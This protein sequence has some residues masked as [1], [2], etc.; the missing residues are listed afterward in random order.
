MTV[1]INEL[2]Q[3]SEDLGFKEIS[4]RLKKIETKLNKSDCPLV[5]PLVGEFSSGKTTLIN[6][7][8][9]SK[10]LE[11]ATRPT[12]ATIYEVHFGS[13]ECKAFVTDENGKTTELDDIKTL[14]NSELSDSAVVTV[15][16]TSKKVPSSIV[17][18]DTPGL[19]SPDPRHRQ[20]LIDF[21]PQ[22][23]AVLL[24][25]DINAQITR[26]LTDFVK[27]MSLSNK[28]L[29][30][31]LTKTDTKS[32]TE[33][34]ATRKY[35]EE[36]LNVNKEKIV[37]VSAQEGKLDELFNLFDSI[38]KDKTQ[39]L[40]KVNEER[41]RIIA[42]D[43]ATRVNE[44]LKAPNNSK[45]IEGQIAKKNIELRKIQRKIED[46]ISSAS[47]DI[48]DIQRKTS[49][50]FE[51]T[52]FDGLESL[53]SGKSSNYN[54]E[55]KAVIYNTA[56]LVLNEYKGQVKRILHDHAAKGI[57]NEEL[58]TSLLDQI[59]VSGLSIKGLSYNLDLDSLGHKYDKVIST[60][61][62]VALA[63]ALVAGTVATA[64][65]AASTIG[66]GAG[67][68]AGGAATGAAAT[69]GTA[70]GAAAETAAAVSTGVSALDTAS[71]IGSM[72]SAHKLKSEMKKAG[73]AFTN[74]VKKKS[75]V[76]ADKVK[77]AEGYTETFNK[78]YDHINLVESNVSSRIGSKGLLDSAIGAFT[79]KTMGKPQ[80]RRAIHQ[81]MD[82][83]LIP[84]FKS[85]LSELT[86]TV[87]DGIRQALIQ[88]AEN[89]VKEMTEAL[90]S[91]KNTMD[92]ERADYDKRIS[93]LREYKKQLNLMQD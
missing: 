61:L 28:Q 84:Q 78:E 47:D 77:K 66:A 45:D 92:K 12:T 24:V 65:A 5:L 26:S 1:D 27:T 67:A 7:L 82:N 72:M 52:V 55:A 54:E 31:V 35:I 34:E 18:V 79:D 73:K 19:S 10:I 70:A 44:L 71:D 89:S 83:T 63:A 38:Q 57:G 74:G 46:S 85:Q 13:E 36:N 29:Y 41:L 22:A 17:L 40:I 15:F 49:R 48:E 37:C 2:L 93:T 8:T 56:S 39:I 50:K 81:Y 21:L 14:K 23:D 4:N 76:V 20:T 68:T 30:L 42:K 51:D 87:V 43:M 59:D 3:I 90:R 25:A 53:T 75:A 60:G 69:G 62:K 58:D 64:G 16:D 9:E 80:R 91:L 33:T 32:L 86:S 6:S 88:G 11:T